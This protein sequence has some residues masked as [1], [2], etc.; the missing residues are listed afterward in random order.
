MDASNLIKPMLASGELRCIGSTTYQE[1]RGIFEKDRALSRRFQKIDVTEPTSTETV[2]IL[3][4]L[5]SRFEEHHQV[6]LLRQGAA[7]G[8]RALG[9]L[10]QRAS[11]A[12]QGH[13]RHRRGRAPHKLLAAVEAPQEDR[14]QRR[15]HRAVVAKIARIPPTRCRPADKDALRT[16]SATSRWWCSGRTR[17]SSRWRRHQDGSRSGSRGREAHRLLPVR[18]PHRRRQDR[19]VAQL[20][21]IMGI[22]L[23]R[24]DMSE[25][26]ERHTVSRLIGAPPGYVGFDQG[27]L[28]TEAMTKHPH[29]CCCST[30]S[31]R[32]TRT[33]STCCC[34]SWTTARS[35]TTTDARRTSATS[36]SS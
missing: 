34:R 18:R 31:R 13:R 19:G 22:E 5:K 35:P 30:R 26:M 16:S 2:K 20:A 27:G 33:C 32:R 3:K 24:F 1:Y 29:A 10:H 6:K 4:G 23:L 17:R 9:P 14:W 28:L 25:Y 21:R 11:P 36:C 7:R 12:G 8:G 15:R